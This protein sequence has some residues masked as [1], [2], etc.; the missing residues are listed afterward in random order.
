MIRFFDFLLSL[1]GLFFLSPIFIFILIIGFFENGSP[2]FRQLRVGRDQKPFLLVKFRTMEINTVSTPTHLVNPL[3]V[4]WFGHILRKTKL[5]EIPQLWNVLKGDMSLVGPRPSLLSQKK[6]IKERHKKGVLKVR[7]G[8]TGL[9][10][11]TGITMKNPVLL[12]KIDFKMIHQ[13]NIYFFFYYILK[14]L[15]LPF[16]NRL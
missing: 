12:A 16:K 15:L 14:T 6:L 7:P 2:L 4:T 1:L 3:S 8:V 10:Q 9:A 5:D 13:M 11:I